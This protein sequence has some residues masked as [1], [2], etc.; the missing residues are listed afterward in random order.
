MKR[1][2][3][4]DMSCDHCAG[5]ITKAVEA[6]DPDAAVTVDLDSKV[7]SIDT[8]GSDDDM[9]SAIRSAG[10]EPQPAA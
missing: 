8:A 1:Y 7:V 5:T 3:V 2:T 4:D 10:Y 6:T 9:R